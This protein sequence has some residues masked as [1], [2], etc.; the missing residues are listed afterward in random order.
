MKRQVNVGFI[1]AGNM[2]SSLIGGLLADGFPAEAIWASDRDL[3]KLQS[4]AERTGI[5]VAYTNREIA[6][7]CDLV[8]LAVKPQQ[9]REVAVEI[10]P[11]VRERGPLIVSIAAGIRVRDLE[12]WLGGEAAIVRAMPNT[13]AL[14]QSGASGLYANPRVTA[15]QKDEAEALLRAVGMAVWVEQETLLDVVTAVSGSGPAYFFLLME[16]ME[17]TA[18]KL[19]LA[20]DT[21]RLL[22]E[23]TALGAAKLALEAEVGPEEL[24]RRVTSPGGTTERAV[25]VLQQGGF[26]ELIAKALEAAL[27]R[28][29][30]LSAQWGGEE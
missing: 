15:K 6:A 5:R 17:K 10:A 19:G 25:A 12:R 28:A 24:R 7:C 23:Q 3:V 8:V 26:E 20:P 4:L 29:A 18:A 22:I 9:M 14:V 2:A 11:A 16:A 30:E 1:G 13:P 21:A 27:R